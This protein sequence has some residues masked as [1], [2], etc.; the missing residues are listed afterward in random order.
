MQRIMQ[1]II[2]YDVICEIDYLNGTHHI[3]L[4]TQ[5]RSNHTIPGDANKTQAIKRGKICEKIHIKDP[6]IKKC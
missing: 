2:F 4:C 5:T 1:R 6:M 3:E